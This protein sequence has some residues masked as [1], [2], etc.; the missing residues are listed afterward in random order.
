M[1]EAKR[2]ECTPQP[3]CSTWFTIDSAPKDGTR[4][5]LC[6]MDPDIG[7]DYEVGIYVPNYGCPGWYAAGTFVNPVAWIPIPSYET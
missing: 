1:N 7:E 6:F 4:V 3:S 5:L 2:N